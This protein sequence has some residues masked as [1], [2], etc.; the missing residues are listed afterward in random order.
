[1]ATRRSLSA[2][3]DNAGGNAEGD[4]NAGA[5]RSTR[6]RRNSGAGADAST[7]AAAVATGAA[8]ADNRNDDEA[9]RET[10]DRGANAGRNA[11]EDR[12]EQESKAEEGG[13]NNNN[14]SAS[15][16]QSAFKLTVAEYLERTSTR[17]TFSTTGI[18]G[19][20]VFDPSPGAIK[21]GEKLRRFVQGLRRVIGEG[22]IDTP[23]ARRYAIKN[24]VDINDLVRK[25]KVPAN[26]VK[27]FEASVIQDLL[28]ISRADPIVDLMPEW[29]T[30]GLY[31]DPH[32]PRPAEL[33]ERD[34]RG[35]VLNAHADKVYWA[36]LGEEFLPGI[37]D[38]ENLLK[39][40]ENVASASTQSLLQKLGW[41]VKPLKESTA[42]LQLTPGAATA[43]SAATLPPQPQPPR[44]VVPAGTDPTSKIGRAHV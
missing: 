34:R 5:G 23:N 13:E 30:D 32:A 24:F 25:L 7:R 12:K 22:D 43:T 42:A 35:A 17:H 8:T 38:V 39:R 11:Q 21:R 4:T 15:D 3:M 31:A 40:S 28:G 37:T 44:V 33:A 1:M 6:S 27:K 2:A 29:H 36:I 20:G 10:P 16:L 26:T 18:E 41:V 9:E 14:T 19:K